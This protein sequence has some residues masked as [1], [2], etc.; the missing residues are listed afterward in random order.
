MPPTLRMESEMHFRTLFDR[1]PVGMATVGL[2][3]GWLEVN[4]ALL[5]F[6]GYRRDELLALDFQSVTHPD[7][8]VQD[9]D[10]VDQV[11]TL[12]RQLDLLGH[13]IAE[14]PAATRESI[15]AA[16]DRLSRR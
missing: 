1:S 15:A 7:D 13:A 6:L 2:D 9:L 3:G 16:L 14:Q 4:D 10:L 12:R 11:H 5:S 8:L